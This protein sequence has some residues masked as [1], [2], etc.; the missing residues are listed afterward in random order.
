MALQ[1][2][3]RV[4]CNEAP[5]TEEGK[6]E[7]KEGESTASFIATLSKCPRDLHVLWH[8]YKFGIG[9]QKPAK[10]FSPSEQ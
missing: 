2:A 5:S 10:D 8:E 6:E 1:P 4:V 9:G 7:E 3:Q